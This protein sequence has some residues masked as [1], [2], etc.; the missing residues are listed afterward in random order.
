[1]KTREFHCLLNRIEHL[2]RIQVQELLTKAQGVKGRAAAIAEIETRAMSRG[3]CPHCGGTGR[4]KWGRT[5][6]NIQRYRCNYCRA[7]FTGRTGSV[8]NGLHRPD[9]FLQV[10]GDMLGKRAPS[11]VRVLARELGLNKDTVWAWRNLILQALNAGVVGKLAGIAE[12]DETFQR[13]SRKGSREWVQHQRNPAAHPRPPRQRWKDY[14][15][16]GALMARGLSR[17]QLPILTATDRNGSRFA[18][19]IPDRRNRTIGQALSPLLATDVVLCSDGLSAYA[20]YARAR[21]IAHFVV[22]AKP[23][24]R[25]ASATH[26]IQNVNAMHARYR[27]FIKPFC[28]PASKYLQRYVDWFLARGRSEPEEVFRR[29][30]GS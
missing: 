21:Q 11:S 14:S 12:V 1:M 13:E 3:V 26:H 5:R 7:T 27:D 2:S 6:T 17:W 20:A 4:Q 15:S 28:G 16:K 29:I 23:R 9:L 8:L 25:K 10:L 30:L 22:G 19:R 24:T 18:A